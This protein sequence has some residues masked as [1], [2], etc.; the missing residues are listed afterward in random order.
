MKRWH[1]V[2]VGTA[3]VGVIA[4]GAAVLWIVRTAE[5]R[6]RRE[7]EVWLSDRLNSEVALASLTVRLFPA[8]RL[9]GTGLVLRIKDRPDL[10]PFVTVERWTGA[11]AL[12]GLRSRRLEAVRL[13]GVTV[14][15]PP[16]RKADL[17]SLTV[18]GGGAGDAAPADD[19]RRR[20]R[21]PLVDRLVAEAVT[22]TV[23]PRHADRDPVVWDVRDLELAPFSLDEAAPFSATVD[24]PLP[25]DRARVSGMVGPWPRRDFDRLPLSGQFT[26]EGD[27]AGVPGLAGRLVA[28]GEVLGTLER[29]ATNGVA[30]S[31]ALGLTTAAPGRLPMT[32]TFEAAFDGTSGD[33]FLSSLMTTVGRSAF[34]TTG[35]ITRQK[36][37]RGRHV[38]LAVSTPDPVELAD[39]L[40]LLVD[41]QRPP[42][43][44]RLTIDAALEMAPGD[45]DV[46]DR[47][48]LAGTFR[49]AGA[50]FGNRAVQEKV[51]DL[52]RR[53][54]GRP[55]DSA[56]R[57]VAAAMRGRVRVRANHLTLRDIRFAV[58]GAEIDAAGGYRLDTE[59]LDFRGVA[60]LDAGM[61]R[62][63][64]GAKRLLLRPLDPLLSKDGAGTR[65]VLDI[66]GSKS[67]PTVD[68]DLGASLRGRR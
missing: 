4:G 49:V 43:S 26:F 62:T 34:K 1:Q 21:P 22:V 47:L 20:P 61:S 30:S 60:R 37:V 52:A 53:G 44:G 15:V 66:R 9:E 6:L 42:V 57:G 64:T 48:D 35:S 19:G 11:G 36:G 68:I 54:Q 65:L 18:D 40:R 12:R 33:L 46:I 7:L 8:V 51:D 45:A 28:S 55:D 14:T 67:D 16:G 27:L 58:P 39:V 50:T 17:R 56:I 25:Q 38:H 63:L 59:R 5:P 24:T 13:E 41:G 2:L 29:L 32:A 31:P 10:P 3:F 23:L